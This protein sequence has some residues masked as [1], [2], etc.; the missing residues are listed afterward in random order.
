[1]APLAP[2]GAEDLAAAILFER[3][4][5]AAPHIRAAIAARL[6]SAPALRTVQRWLAGW[7]R[8]NRRA[9][10][11]VAAPKSR[12]GRHAP[13][14]GQAL[15]L[16]DRPHSV[17]EIDSSPVDLY[18]RGA[19]RLNF[20]A[21]VCGYS[22]LASVAVTERS[23]GEAICALLRRAVLEYGVPEAIRI[24]NGADYVSARLMGAYRR[25][26]VAVHRCLPGQPD[27]KPFVERFFRTLQ[28]GLIAHL[29]GYVGPDVAA[30]QRLRE[31]PRVETRLTPAELQERVDA[32]VRNVYAHT[33]HAGLGGRT[34]WLAAQ[35]HSRAARP[36]VDERALDVLLADA[37]L[38][39]VGRH[40]IS[41]RGGFYVAAELGDSVGERVEVRV[42]PA[43]YGRVWVFRGGAF[44]CAA[45]DRDR[46]GV[47]L[48]EIAARAKARDRESV[49]AAR[50]EA[51]RLRAAHRPEETMDDI[52]AARAR[53]AAAVV[54]LPA[55]APALE[56]REAAAARAAAESSNRGIGAA[57]PAPETGSGAHRARDAIA[58]L[59]GRRR[60]EG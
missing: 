39:T 44:L 29:P 25:L 11:A 54:A 49:R 19:G 4:H 38:R 20:V 33:P 8:E 14:F 26:G 28:E 7:R 15:G 35:A 42:D 12:R 13:A 58:A 22:R 47:G 50:A 1:M 52:L 41:V 37:V 46:A 32:W 5:A 43:D 2:D 27:R 10:A 3:P 45:V 21:Q 40:G 31:R 30:A 60:R 18:C 48:A 23:N 59:Y 36:R 6:G 9:L 57:A 53:A 34:P 55:P 24:D 17:W 51:R 16:A 56:S